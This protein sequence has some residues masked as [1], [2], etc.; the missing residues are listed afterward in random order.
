MSISI[1]FDD[2]NARGRMKKQRVTPWNSNNV[3]DFPGTRVREG[4]TIGGYI[5]IVLGLIWLI[6]SLVALYSYVAKIIPPFV[7]AA[8]TP[9]IVFS[10]VF[11][12][13]FLLTGL[14]F[15][16][17]REVITIENERVVYEKES[18]FGQKYWQEPLK[19][20][21]GVLQRTEYRSGGKNSPSYTLYIVELCHPDS[22][23]TLL[24]HE[25]R[26]DHDFRKTWEAYSRTLKVPALVKE[27]ERII[28]RAVEDL[29]KSIK[30]LAE[31]GKIDISFD[32]AQA[33]PVGVVATVEKDALK[34]MLPNAPFKASNLVGISVFLLFPMVFIYIGFF[35]E[36]ASIA[37]GIMGSI[38]LLVVVFS[39]IWKAIAKEVLWVSSKEVR[40][41]YE[42]PWG[43]R[44]GSALKTKQVE[45]VRVGK[46]VDD[47]I[48]RNGLLIISDELQLKVGEG[49]TDET[50]EWLK[51]CV[52]A[53]ITRK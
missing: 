5:F 12:V 25:S 50:L 32:P 16:R 49:L 21:Q 14:H 17:F 42:T 43:E 36:D 46:R 45:A 35:L 29:D 53:V 39:F 20:F 30:E 2:K 48:N 24:L 6:P 27:G 23:K 1:S 9:F 38:F 47:R 8:D 18:L 40:F 41:F 3:S 4:S 33:P 52:L 10:I 11:S 22:K 34:M 31:E 26:D 15:L 19:N 28:K 37:F 44:P 7:L 13:G 51:Q